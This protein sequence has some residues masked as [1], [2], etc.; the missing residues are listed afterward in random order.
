MQR[1]RAIVLLAISLMGTPLCA[2]KVS[3]DFDKDADFMP[4]KT[5]KWVDIGSGKAAV[6]TTHKLIVGDVDVQ[7]QA[8]GVKLAKDGDP[9]LF[10]SYQVVTEKKGQIAS[11]NPD[12]QWNANALKPSPGNLAQG[13]L[14]VD[15]YDRKMKKLVWRG[16]VSAAFSS[17]QEVNYIVSKGISKLFANYPPH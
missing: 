12:G 10:V 3:F 17:R 14:I 1:F 13:S 2:Q 15:L 8:R 5:Y 6:E 9:D 4:Y 11:F 16:I 7:L